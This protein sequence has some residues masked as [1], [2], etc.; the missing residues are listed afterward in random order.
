MKLRKNKMLMY[1]LLTVFTIDIT[2]PAIAVNANT[3]QGV[4][5]LSNN[6]N[7]IENGSF[8]K[9]LEKWTTWSSSN[10]FKVE[11]DSSKFKSGSNSV[12][13]YNSSSTPIS[14]FLSYQRVD[15]SK[16][17]GKNLSLKHCISSENFKGDLQIRITYS[18]VNGQTVGDLDTKILLMNE[19]SDWKNK[20]NIISIPNN[21]NIKY[22]K[23]EYLYNNATGNIWIDDVIMNVNATE[24]NN[25]NIIKNG[26]FEDDFSYWT[27]WG[28]NNSYVVEIDEVNN[29]GK[30]SLKIS[31]SSQNTTRGI[32]SQKIKLQDINKKAIQVQQYIKSQNFKGEFQIVA[33]FLD[34]NSKQI[35]DSDVK[36]INILENS[37]WTI[38]NNIIEIPFNEKIK[39]V[40][41]QYVYNN[42][43]GTVWIDDINMQIIDYDK[44][45]NII[46]N[47]DFEEG[48]SYW[49]IWKERNELAM[50]IVHSQY[51]SNNSSMHIYNSSN[52]ETR[53]ILSQKVNISN[54]LLGKTINL[55][56]SIKTQNLRGENINLRVRFKDSND[57]YVEDSQT[58]TLGVGNTQDWKEI[59]YNIYIPNNSKIKYAQIEY[60]FEKILGD[61]W[62]DDI[63]ASEIENG[64]KL[65]LV[66]NGNFEST[67]KLPV[68]SW[69]INNEDNRFDCNVDKVEKVEGENSLK[70]E[71]KNNSRDNVIGQTIEVTDNLRGK[72]IKV[73]EFIKS[74]KI[75]AL[76]KTIKFVG[77]SN[78][79]V[80]NT[81]SWDRG[82]NGSSEWIENIN[83]IKIPDD[84]KI[85]KII[86]EYNFLNLNERVYI[87]DV[88]IEPYVG[89]ENI[90][91][92]EDVI[93]LKVGEKKKL[94]FNVT[95]ESYTNKDLVIK[96][97]NENIFKVENGNIIGVNN[98]SAKI[99]IEQAYESIR[100]EFPIIVANQFNN[101]IS[102]NLKVQQGSTISDKIN[103][104]GYNNE[105]LKF[106]VLIEGKSGNI[107]LKQ[108]G[109]FNYYLNQDFSGNDTIVI[110]AKDSKGNI[111][112]VKYNLTIYKNQDDFLNKDYIIVAMENTNLSGKIEIGNN[113]KVSYYLKENCKNGNISIDQQGNYSFNPNN[114]FN[115][116]DKF[117]L[118]VISD[119]ESSIIEHKVYVA[120]SISSLSKLINKDHPK[121]ILKQD[122]YNNIKQLIKSDDLA[123]AWFNIIK[124]ETDP[125]LNL[126]TVTYDSNTLDVTKIEGY[127]Q[128]LSFMYKFTGESKYADRVI[129]ELESICSFSWD[130]GEFLETASLAAAVA[131]A[132]DCLYDYLSIDQRK[133]IEN[134]IIEKAL[135]QAQK[136]YNENSGFVT[137]N[138]NWNIVCNSAMIFSSLAIANTEN[139]DITLKI[140]QNGLMSIQNTL[141]S[142]YKDGS[143][144]E[145][146]GYWD[147][148]TSHLI[149]AISSIENV[150]GIANPFKDVINLDDM[151]SFSMHINGTNNSFNFADSDNWL[152]KSYYGIWFAKKL[153]NKEYTKYSALQ[154]K[155]SNYVTVFDLLW[156][157]PSLYDTSSI[158][159][160]DKKYDD[161]QLVTMR[162][163]FINDNSSY[164]AFKGGT[165]AVDHADLDI[166]TFVFDSLG[167]RWAEELGK[168]DYSLPGYW[169]YGVNGKRWSYY[170][171]RAEG[172]NTL[173][174]GNKYNEDQV[175]GT[176]SKIIESRLN[177]D[178]PYAILDMTPAYKD[179]SINV[180]RKIQ[181]IN[182]RKDLVI[183][184]NFI[185]KDM[186][187][188]V[189]NMHTT[190]DI[191]VLNNGD[192]LIL[193]KDGQMLEMSIESDCNATFKVVEAK[194]SASSPNPSQQTQNVG[195]KKIIANVKVKSG[196]IKV[197]LMPVGDVYSNKDTIL[198]GSFEDGLNNWGTW[199]SLGNIKI[200]LNN[201]EYIQGRNSVSINT[202][203][204]LRGRG[205]ISQVA[206]ISKYSSK[207]FNIGQ[208]IKNKSFT[209]ELVQRVSFMNSI[210]EKIGDTIIDKFNV[211]Q[212]KDWTY[213]EKTYSIPKGAF[214]VNIEY[215]YDG[216]GEILIDDISNV[217]D[218]LDINEDGITDILDL[219]IVAMNYNKNNKSEG[220]YL[221]ADIN[222]DGIVDLYDLILISK[223]I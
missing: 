151:A 178:D 189:W 194:P 146:P 188:V 184:D 172:H 22:M 217:I 155:N 73:S 156:Y 120:P 35:V 88:R 108:D 223:N 168:E 221:K 9:N 57:N 137:M 119:G 66:Q 111:V 2:L 144:V 38:K 12:K 124:G 97:S 166:G 33:K 199:D 193:R 60:V 104:Q 84:K 59:A 181:L 47:G 192:R 195:V 169:D 152:L 210:G 153:N 5:V 62:I 182:S 69:Y 179:K 24:N 14:G 8:E 142:Y 74:P 176:T 222:K 36:T 80:I 116:Y 115:G 81:T 196:Y 78:N 200:Q 40:E 140:V 68:T 87:D 1:L 25:N 154:Y 30:N 6:Q 190:A 67:I 82:L 79:D 148:S 118:E 164:V 10:N 52:I 93:Q 41:I 102:I 28:T 75:N 187:D 216:K 105:D 180:Q 90:R 65:N 4:E 99:I 123:K 13:I 54:E 211:D 219:A 101:N 34:E 203:N 56:Q 212:G 191:Q 186:E 77:D 96:S 136:N 31:N 29:T 114:N 122:G 117:K 42:S 51:V 171:K 100:Y 112:L 183:E 19:K 71:A 173:T 207:T 150:L 121:I 43:L 72:T 83:Y 162:S 126:P 158:K 127:L 130:T 85:K 197:K 160:L 214:K 213:H 218:F 23:M 139:Y 44:E 16:W 157:D 32:I 141:L 106:N 170:R 39:Y 133:K 149:Y 177:E 103:I 145:G 205:A 209:G 50:D 27:K 17:L 134:A 159:E 175:I 45:P 18:D 48:T 174:I 165:T 220:W 113:E 53:G 26:N 109:S 125:I 110:E 143:C 138:N 63:N 20:S 55:K 107:N 135:K 58:Y 185:L 15:V 204:N 76:L 37:D 201:D 21:N 98:G 3:T 129:R 208:W 131:I 7:I 95:P 89:I 147:F 198:N 86:I 167:V 64:G 91:I 206:N 163:S 46:K 128:N 202:N 70:L 11:V 215:I 92:E 49:T 94:S 61:L 161:L 132:Y